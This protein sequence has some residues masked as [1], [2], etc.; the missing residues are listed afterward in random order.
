ADAVKFQTFRADRLYPR[1]A[2]RSDYLG[3]ERSIYDIIR[4][5]EMPPEW[6]PILAE[7]ARARGVAFLSSTFDEASVELVDP[8]VDAF[9]C[10]SYEMTH[11]PLLR[12]MARRGKPLLLSTGTAT[13]P[14]VEDA[15]CAARA[16][17]NHDLVVLQ[18]TAAYPAPL[19]SINARALVTM[20]GALDVLTGLS[21]H[22]R[23]PIAAPVTAAALGAVVL[24]K[25]FTLSNHLPGPDHA[26][27]V[28]PAE[29]AEMIRRVREVERARGSGE[30][31]VHPVEEELRRFA[32]RS[33]FATRRIEPGERLSTECSAVLR[34]GKL[35][36]GLAPK[37]YPE[38]LGREVIR[39]L[40]PDAPV[41]WADLGAARLGE[42]RAPDPPLV[43]LREAGPEDCRAVWQWKN[44]PEVRRSAFITRYV[45]WAEH[46]AWYERRMRLP[47]RMLWM[48][49]AAGAEVG[50]I[51]IDRDGGVGVA[52]I[53]LAPEARGRGI[54]ARAIALACARAAAQGGP[55]R[56][57]ALI[58][59][60][61]ERSA[62]A[63]RRAGFTPA[64][65]RDVHG[66]AALVYALEQAPPGA[67][68]GGQA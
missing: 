51:R 47:E 31:V 55:A 10:A 9:K 11:E 27:A 7:H 53:A 68:A 41:T 45:P 8:H 3:D 62:R 5:M 21:D 34:A 30:K 43:A 35:E 36:P 54:G 66:A 14:E 49:E 22:S 17:G 61:N 40:A 28:E 42:E 44:E 46:A 64:G 16:A 1:S 32:R 19:E 67:P 39:P 2:G 33:V 25:H 56:V 50:W 18:C 12:F 6:L 29:L 59:P 57:E 58:R 48:I 15:V 38:A 4:A 24:E 37:D 52:S 60:D 20:R 23:D 65:T 63:F 26:F 13:L